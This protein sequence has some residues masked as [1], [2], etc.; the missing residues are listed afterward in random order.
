[1]LENL[2]DT[3][4]ATVGSVPCRFVRYP[5][6]CHQSPLTRSC[7][8]IKEGTVDNIAPTVHDCTRLCTPQCCGSCTPQ[9]CGSSRSCNFC[10]L[11][12]AAQTSPAACVSAGPGLAGRCGTRG[13][14]CRPTASRARGRG[15][16]RGCTQCNSGGPRGRAAPLINSFRLNVK[17]LNQ[18]W[19]QIECCPA[20]LASD[21][22]H[23]LPIEAA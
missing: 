18:N 1:V 2:T 13:P 4:L 11:E 22:S 20:R 6:R 3:G 10:R 15:A 21:D 12:G 8:E 5:Y 23:P 7:R 9:C 19:N 17:G 16:P 14:L